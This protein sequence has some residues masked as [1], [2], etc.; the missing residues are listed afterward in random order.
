MNPNKNQ[1]IGGFKIAYAK[2]FLWF[3]VLA[4]LATIMINFY[5]YNMKKLPIY[6]SV[7]PAKSTDKQ[8]IALKEKFLKVANNQLITAA[9]S[10]NLWQ[11]IFRAHNQSSRTYHN[12]SH[13]Y[14]ISE[15]LD[16]NESKDLD[17]SI[18]YWTTFFHDY[19]YKATRKDNEIKSAAFAKQVLTA[20]LPVEQIALISTIIESTARHEPLVEIPEQYVFLDADLAVL[21]VEE[22][23]YD[24]YV[25]AIRREYRIYPDLLYRPGRR[26]VL[27]HFL[28]RTTIYYTPVFQPYEAQARFN[29]K[30]EIDSLG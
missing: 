22:D 12:L 18:L 19:V 23:L 2:P 1:E 27:Q 14:S 4:N 26:K 30:R 17:S 5:F 3:P 24:Q 9:D 7:S 21:A 6:L 13:L 25:Q 28:E 29:L 8:I 10:E 16:Q 15:I 20:F 11:K